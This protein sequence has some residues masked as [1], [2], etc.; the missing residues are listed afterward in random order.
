MDIS[1]IVS[2]AIELQKTQNV[3][4]DVAIIASAMGALT[5][6]V[7]TLLEQK[8]G[9]PAA[10]VPAPTPATELTPPLTL[11]EM[12]SM[13]NDIARKQPGN[14]AR[15]A[16]LLQQYGANKLTQVAPKDYAAVKAAALAL[17]A[18]EKAAA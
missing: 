1:R 2:T 14:K 3:S 11:D 5:L 8:T 9:I 17:D 16:A 15:L 10:P 18:P 12:R 13:F 7:N 4:M 6:S